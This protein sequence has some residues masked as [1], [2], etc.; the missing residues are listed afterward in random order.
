MISA[1]VAEA[2]RFGRVKRNGY[3]P[4]E[5]DAV[6]TR[7]V[8][9]LR[10]YE[11]KTEALEERL[12]EADASADAIRRTFLAAEATRDEIV[13]AANAE[14]DGITGG[15]QQEADAILGTARSSAAGLIASA[16]ADA[17]AMAELADRLDHEIAQR[18]DEILS[19]AHEKA[20]TVVTE[21]EWSAAQQKLAAVAEANQVVDAATDEAA[22]LRSE[23]LMGHGA[24]TTA[25]A[26]IT[27][28]ATVRA[29]AILSDA[30]AEADRIIADAAT[31]ST[32]LK[33][34]AAALRVAVADL[35]RSAGELAALTSE[36]AAVLDLSQI[37]AMDAIVADTV[38]ADA[39]GA[40][41]TVDETADETAEVEDDVAS[42][43]PK[44]LDTPA[45]SEEMVEEVEE[46]H[47]HIDI[48]E[49]EDDRPLLSVAEAQ[50]AIDDEPETERE[51]VATTYYQRS[52]GIPLSE[53]IKI[54]RKSG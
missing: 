16:E 53:R 36:E 54:A 17:A 1:S 8:E 51:P 25:A 28:E 37:E 21:A 27:A 7:L 23:A 46:L 48:R 22:E 24:A 42:V 43:D 14:A 12:A 18:R 45:A 35:Q 3:D 19:Q 15:A 50:D 41:T 40:G 44:P 26:R 11:S 29:D 33:N 2:H 49:P 31:D 9:T 30:Q 47:D 13:E 10:T 32:S 39:A 38:V 34:K 52:T 4:V 20:E 6:V 5:V